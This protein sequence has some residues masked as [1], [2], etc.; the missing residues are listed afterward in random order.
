MSRRIDQGEA[1]AAAS[2]GPREATPLSVVSFD[3]VTI[4]YDWY[5]A[6]SR[7]IAL[8]I[9]GFWRD[10]SY[11]SM[12]R[13][14]S[15][16]NGLGYSAAIIDV[17][18]HGDSGGTYGFNR[19]EHR[20]VAAVARDLLARTPAECLTLVGFS[21]GA[22][23]AISTAA[24]H[25]LPIASLLLISPVADFRHVIPRINPLTLHRHIALRQALKRPRFDWLFPRARRIRA[26]D[27]IP[28]VSVPVSFIH[29]KNDWLVDHSH[30]VRLY[31]SANEPR[32]LHIIDI[33]GNYHADRIFSQ[34]GGE[35]EPLVSDFLQR[36][37]PR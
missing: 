17:R 7:G 2:S 36:Y 25:D 13:L 1:A 18:G 6:G 32:E 28:R 14:A 11:P 12:P 24:R 29:V 35:I 10:R 9:P 27:D 20:D 30:S 15:L 8:V 21:V 22:A 4:H 37:T 33:P 26:I 5:A 16:L 31:E 19:D 23:I 3:G 34:A